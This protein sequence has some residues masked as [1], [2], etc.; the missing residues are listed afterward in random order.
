[1][2]LTKI[3]CVTK[4]ERKKRGKK[5]KIKKIGPRP[6]QLVT[7]C[8]R[9]RTEAAVSTSEAPERGPDF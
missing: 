3:Y 2:S 4:I 8:L 5:T 6:K 7:A 1:M 9:S